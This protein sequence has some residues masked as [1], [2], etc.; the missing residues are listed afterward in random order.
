MCP[1]YSLIK[2]F[3][4]PVMLQNVLHYAR[5]VVL[6]LLTIY[7]QHLEIVHSLITQEPH[8]GT[9]KAIMHYALQLEKS[10]K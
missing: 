2:Y 5:V 10:S 4:K 3:H 9:R 1:K 6:H 8:L 7:T